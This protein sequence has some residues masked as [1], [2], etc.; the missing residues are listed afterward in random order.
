MG[1]WMRL[2][3]CRNRR[4]A[5]SHMRY[6]STS[7]LKSPNK[8]KAMPIVKNKRAE[9]M[10]GCVSRQGIGR[11]CDLNDARLRMFFRPSTKLL[12][13]LRSAGSHLSSS[14]YHSFRVLFDE[15]LSQS[16]R[17]G[18]T[19]VSQRCCCVCLG[20]DFK[21]TSERNP[22]FERTVLLPNARILDMMMSSIRTTYP[23]GWQVMRCNR[24]LSLGE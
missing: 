23:I 15:R 18:R 4:L 6:R 24:V 1:E 5:K 20:P 2:C 16:A 17:L 22:D 3:H 13:G 14:T 9:M 7:Q 10:E 12:D 19:A 8:S 21:S 11:Q